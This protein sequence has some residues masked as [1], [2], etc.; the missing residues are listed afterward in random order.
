MSAQRYS[1]MARADVSD[2][3]E[4]FYNRNRRHNHLGSVSSEAF[5]KAA[6]CGWHVA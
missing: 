3:I 6:A 2:Y 5:E 1:T 4:V